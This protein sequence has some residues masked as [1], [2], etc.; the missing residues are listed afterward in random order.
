VRLFFA[1]LFTAQFT[2]QKSAGSAVALS[3]VR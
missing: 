1:A 2:E 3:K